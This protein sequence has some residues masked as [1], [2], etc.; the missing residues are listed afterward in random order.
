MNS[1]TPKDAT[2]EI[3]DST[4]WLETPLKSL[5]AVEAALR[6]QICKE[7]Y[8]TPLITSCE[9]TFCSLCIR[10]CLNQDGKCPACRK[11]DQSSRLRHCKTLG[12]LVQ[13]FKLAR[14]EVFAFATK[15]SATSPTMPPNRSR[16][17]T[18]EMQEDGEPSRKRTRSSRQTRAKSAQQM[19]VLDSDEDGDFVPEEKEEHNDGRVECPIC[20]KRV[21]EASINLHID[22]GCPNEPS[23]P[24]CE[25]LKSISSPSRRGQKNAEK[26]LERLAQVNYGMMNERQVRKKAMDLGLLGHGS[27]PIM[28]KRITEWVTLWNANCDATFPKSKAELK[29]DM[30]TWERTQGVYAPSN[31]TGNQIKSK[32]FDAAAWSNQHDANFKYLIANA[33]KKAQAAKAVATTDDKSESAS[34]TG[35]SSSNKSGPSITWQP[36]EPHTGNNTSAYESSYTASKEDYETHTESHQLLPTASESLTYPPPNSTQEPLASSASNNQQPTSNASKPGVPETKM[37][38]SQRERSEKHNP[39]WPFVHSDRPVPFMEPQYIDGSWQAVQTRPHK[40][41]ILTYGELAIQEREQ[42]QRE[43]KQQNMPGL[44]TTSQQPPPKR[45]SQDTN[46][47]PVNKSGIEAVV[48]IDNPTF[49]NIQY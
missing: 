41:P 15:P 42:E 8:D 9:H 45:P 30:D 34:I 28:E 38:L 2:Y 37:S 3:T 12:E 5:S 33:R 21:K 19:I 13:S 43:R 24:K 23:T 31:S 44:H 36:S 29:R 48:G 39:N 27:K 10:R 47:I 25:K 20:A 35:Q 46:S 17:T 11:E 6:C 22:R 16:G 7:F 18:P 4:D 40:Y 1:K 49:T 14:P 26:P 32:D